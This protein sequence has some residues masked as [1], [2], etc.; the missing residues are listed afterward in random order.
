MIKV[1]EISKSFAG[2][3]AVDDVNFEV[4]K[5]DV[6]GFLGPNGAGKTTTMRMVTG[7]TV[8]DEGEVLIDGTRY[9]QDEF[10]I[11]SKIGY[12]PE[13]NPLYMDMFVEEFLK[14]TLN[15]HGVEKTKQKER[16]TKAVESTGIESVYYKPIHTLSKGYKQR[17]GLAQVLL[18]DPK[19]LVL[20]EPTEGLDPNQRG[21]IRSLIRNLGKEKT[22]IVSTHVLQEAEAMC[23]RIIIINKGRIIADEKK[24]DILSMKEGSQR[25]YMEV[26]GSDVEK[27]FKKIEDVVKVTIDK[28]GKIQKVSLEVE[29]KDEDTIFKDISNLIRERKW[30]IYKLETQSYK[31]EDIFYKLT[32]S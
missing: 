31:L 7:Y 28:D 23:N 15:L 11:K 9:D 20:D 6:L 8:P 25:V 26:S 32:K 27:S 10:G 13:N 3:K 4:K 12:M 18:N 24:S 19:I 21:D 2:V 5:G 17:V 22:V 16:I 29:S 14:L 1:K 30:V